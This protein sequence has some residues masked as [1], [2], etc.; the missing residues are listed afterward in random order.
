VSPSVFIVKR[1]TAAGE[2]HWQVRYRLGGRE[3]RPLSGGT[4]ETK[5]EAEARR[6][7]VA[8]ELAAMR[9]PDL[10][11]LEAP[12]DV[13][14]LA[15]AIEEM[16]T[17]R[18]DVG[19]S[20]RRQYRKARKRLGELGERD[21]LTI[22]PAHVQAWV[23][24]IAQE[25]APATVASYVSVVRQA[26][27]DLPYPLPNPARHPTVKLPQLDDAE[28]APPSYADFMA[29]A[30]E[31]SSRYRFA[32]EL[33]ERTG[34]R[35]SEAVALTWGDV[36]LAGR[37]LRVPWGGKTNAARRFIPLVEDWPER[38]A[39]TCPLEDRAPGRRVLGGLTDSGVRRALAIA[40]RN[41][42]VAHYSPHELRHRHISLMVLAGIPMPLVIQISGHA[43]QSTT[44]DTYSHVLLDEP[45][46]R[47]AALRRGVLVVSGWAADRPSTEESPA[48]DD[49]AGEMGSTG[50]LPP[51]PHE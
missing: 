44:H 35:I 21:V 10:H 46:W 24:A 51:R 26:L 9:V 1:T 23:R 18:I 19:D 49:P 27:D 16:E 6:R 41:A 36:D 5:R 48:N 30:R 20:A 17:G 38:I 7:W 40:C 31:V 8:G 29:I 39:D 37:R 4:F 15:V 3:A 12:A 50:I 47:L 34:M 45:A 22:R 25:L 28:V 43:K 2:V 32:L 42:G 33:I 14:T 11:A 13:R